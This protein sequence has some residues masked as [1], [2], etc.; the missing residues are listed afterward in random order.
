MASKVGKLS[1]E[2][3]KN[4]MWINKHLGIIQDIR[5]GNQQYTEAVSDIRSCR[6]VSIT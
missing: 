5:S 1:V 6:T 3:L 4:S 2:I